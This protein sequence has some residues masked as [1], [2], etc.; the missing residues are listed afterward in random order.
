MHKWDTTAAFP[1]FHPTNH[2]FD[3][4]TSRGV[5][6]YYP[7]VMARR[8][9]KTVVVHI[10][11]NDIAYGATVEATA[12]NVLALIGRIRNDLPTAR[13]LYLSLKPSPARWSF[14][15]QLQALGR[16]VA[17]RSG[18]RGGFEFVDIGNTLLTPNGQLQPE[19]Y[20][21]DGLHLNPQGY[22]RWKAILDDQLLRQSSLSS[23]APIR[24]AVPRG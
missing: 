2:A 15:P 22:V 9:P 8:R 21:P 14:W 24:G 20:Q 7:Q 19:L 10:G 12:D 13:I 6:H 5:L 11:E 17:A 1:A 16:N 3:D 23:T 18:H 4:A